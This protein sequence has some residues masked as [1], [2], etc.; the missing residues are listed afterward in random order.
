MLN[1]EYLEHFLITTKY[2][3]FTVAAE[4]LFMNQST[5][6]RQISA[7]E[8]E[9]RAALFDRTGRMLR[10]T[11][12][13]LKLQEEGAALLSLQGQVVNSVRAVASLASSKL[14]IYTVPGYFP[15]L[16]CIYERMYRLYP[17]IELS[18][19]HL[20]MMELSASLSNDTADFGITYETHF[21]KDPQFVIQPL[22]TEPFVVICSPDH[23]F[24]ARNEAVT[25]EECLHETILFG[26]DF[27]LFLKGKI[28]SDFF[29]YPACP[30][31]T[32]ESLRYLVL[33]NAGIII[34]PSGSA[35]SC[36]PGLSRVPIRDQDLRHRVVLIYK[37]DKSLS[38][39]CQ[40]FLNEVKN[41]LLEQEP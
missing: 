10:L 37:R 9:C 3:S 38:T 1:L 33:M 18:V 28:S 5:L 27:P 11:D 34:L 6:S 2:M 40:L 36:L 22:E 29:K 41:Y 26:A 31:S 14:N 35:N 4:K 25:F 19:Y 32:L 20:K 15:S 23:P 39:A 21:Q 24:S 30:E 8:E 13:G 17:N 16:D 12:A 7:L